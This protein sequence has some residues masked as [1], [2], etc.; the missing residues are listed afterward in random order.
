MGKVFR[1]VSV[2]VEVGKIF[3]FSYFLVIGLCGWRWFRDKV[4]FWLGG[5]GFGGGY[6]YILRFLEVD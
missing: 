3:G 1:I 6:C 2:L 4:Y 5:E